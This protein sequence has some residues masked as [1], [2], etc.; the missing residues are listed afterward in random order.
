MNLSELKITGGLATG[1]T[2]ALIY[3]G[4]YISDITDLLEKK[5]YYQIFIT[6]KYDNYESDILFTINLK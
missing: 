5:G 6:S 4:E 2:N 3:D 1:I